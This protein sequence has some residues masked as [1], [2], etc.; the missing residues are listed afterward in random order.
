MHRLIPG[1]CTHWKL[2]GTND[3]Y[4]SW[5]GL[6]STVDDKF[7]GAHRDSS[8]CFANNLGKVHAPPEGEEQS[9]AHLIYT[10]STLTLVGLQTKQL[11][12]PTYINLRFFK[13]TL[14]Q[15]SL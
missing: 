5:A 4:H 9:S 13:N 7:H 12:T 6:A 10:T 2:S 14:R 15:F 1:K 8:A 11:T 3:L